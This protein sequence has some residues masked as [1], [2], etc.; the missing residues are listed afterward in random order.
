MKLS[1]ELQVLL[2]LVRLAL[3]TEPLDS[4]GRLVE[5]FPERIDWKAVIDLS[6]QNKVSAL[7]VDGLLSV[8]GQRPDPRLKMWIDDVANMER[9]YDYYLE[10]LHTLCTIFIA[11]GLTPIVLKGYGMGMNYPVPNH[12]AM[13]D[14]DIYLLDKDGNCAAEEGNRLVET[15]LGIKI[16]GRNCD[17]HSAFNFQGVR[18]ENHYQLYGYCRKGSEEQMRQTMHEEMVRDFISVN[19][20]YMPS[21]DVNAVFLTQHMF[22]HYSGL[23]TILRQF[24]DFA[25]F[26]RAHHDK[27]NWKHV[28]SVLDKLGLK[29]FFDGVC[30]LV[31]DWFNIPREYFS[32]T[33]RFDGKV[34][35]HLIHD[36]KLSFR[37]YGPLLQRLSVS[38]QRGWNVRYFKNQS[39]VTM[40]YLEIKRSLGK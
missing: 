21:A 33:Y 4:D 34:E 25:V 13:G 19:G 35:N 7:A 16:T 29:E 32:P 24:S 38:L 5:P 27:I 39:I 11:N 6:Y 10:V 37:Q 40:T 23:E 17:N 18:V 3:G 30:S 8:K 22:H 14:I 12:R 1:T 15:C 20:I 28:D 36:F 26:L 2:K 31:H 9:S